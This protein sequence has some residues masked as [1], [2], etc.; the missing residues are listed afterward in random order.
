MP[1]PRW[2]SRVHRYFEHPQ[3]Y[4]VVKSIE[5]STCRLITVGKSKETI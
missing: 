4:E 1:S 3:G 2:P 5:E